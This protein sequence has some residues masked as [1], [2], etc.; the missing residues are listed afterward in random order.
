MKLHGVPGQSGRN[1][2]VIS[3]RKHT[4]ILYCILFLIAQGMEILYSTTKIQKSILQHP[5]NLCQS[6]NTLYKTKRKW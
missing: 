4:V 1:L 6:H 2:T 5:Q 3:D